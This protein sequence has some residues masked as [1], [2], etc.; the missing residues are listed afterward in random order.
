MFYRRYEDGVERVLRRKT[1]RTTNKSMANPPID[2]TEA[3]FNVL[4]SVCRDAAGTELYTVGILAVLFS[5]LNKVREWQMESFDSPAS[6][7][8]V[9]HVEE[10]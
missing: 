4:Q 9:A 8:G 7:G 5:G 10:G 2:L 3:E 1:Q 6:I